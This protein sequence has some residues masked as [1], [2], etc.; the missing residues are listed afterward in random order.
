M[1]KFES[2][3]V[4]DAIDTLETRIKTGVL[5]H[6]KWIVSACHG[7]GFIARRKRI[8]KRKNSMIICGNMCIIVRKA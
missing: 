7:G 1:A 6:G 8:S 2:E 5:P 3:W 4:I